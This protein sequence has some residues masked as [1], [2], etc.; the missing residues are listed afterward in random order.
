MA[1][2]PVGP[3]GCPL[4]SPDA[5]QLAKTAFLAIEQALRTPIRG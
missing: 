5:H 1:S 2:N 3:G 4:V